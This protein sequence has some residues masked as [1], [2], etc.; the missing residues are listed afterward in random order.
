[1]GDTI[2]LTLRCFAYV[3]GLLALA[4]AASQVGYC[5]DR[6]KVTVCQLKSD[7]AAYNHRL[8][9]VTSFVSHGFEDFGLFDPTCPSWP[10]VWLEYGGTVRS[11]TMYCCGVSNTRNRPEELMVE[12]IA[13]PLVVDDAFQ[14]FDR[15]VQH[16]PDSVV[17]ATIVGR[18]FAG[19]P[20]QNSAGTSWV[21]YG[22]LGC[23]SL[24]AIQQI[25]ST[26]GHD[27]SDLDYRAWPDPP[28][29]DCGYRELVP[30]EL[31]RDSLAAQKA[32]ENGQRDW[33]FDDPL[34]VASDFLVSLLKIGGT[35]IK[36]IKQTSKAQGRFVYKWNASG[37]KAFYTVVVG[38]PYWLSFYSADPKKVAWVIVGA[39]ESRCGRR[40]W[41]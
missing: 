31:Y 39:Y 25:R 10:D 33:A 30:V 4:L 36:G 23:C 19:Q 15:L 13:I 24:L 5:Q 28:R 37:K 9:E 22:H 40:H 17:H 12:N 1:M 34:R 8:V 21:G 2:L 11:G 20:R 3:N 16:Q 32:A 18:F 14:S 26:D 35:S 6:E 7:P 38:R 41:L 27:R 29:T